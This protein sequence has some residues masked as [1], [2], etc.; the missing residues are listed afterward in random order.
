[1]VDVKVLS[2][3]INLLFAQCFS[4]KARHLSDLTLQ[5]LYMKQLDLVTM[6]TKNREDAYLFHIFIEQK[7][8]IW[9]VTLFPERKNVWEKRRE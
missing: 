9:I 2:E 4:Q 1:M 8:Y 3:A 5:V 6:A 7:Q